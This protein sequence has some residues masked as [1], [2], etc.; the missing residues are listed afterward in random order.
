MCLPAAV[1]AVQAAAAVAT[2]VGAQRTFSANQANVR[3]ATAASYSATQDQRVQINAQATDQMNARAQQ[4]MRDAGTLNAIFADSG[5]SGNTQDRLATESQANATQ[6]ITTIER[7]R[8]AGITQT[9][10][11]AAAAR[12]RLQS[13]SNAVRA[14]SLIGTGLQIA[15]AGR[16]L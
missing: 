10:N 6:D 1:L 7:N 14:P 12:A 3:D 4:A 2:Y 11:E 9:A 15:G 8:A 5:L 16:R 13:Q